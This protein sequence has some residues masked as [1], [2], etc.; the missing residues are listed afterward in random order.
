M[1]LGH[2][3]TVMESGINNP[4][5]AGYEDIV[6]HT[7]AGHTHVAD[8]TD[9]AVRFTQVGAVSQV[10]FRSFTLS[11]DSSQ[12]GTIH[13][14]SVR[15]YGKSSHLAL[16]SLKP[17]PQGGTLDNGFFVGNLI[18]SSGEVA[19]LELTMKA[20]FVRWRGPRNTVP[21]VESW[22]CCG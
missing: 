21:S 5:L 17:H 11:H 3:P 4:M 14:N 7:F 20:N 19:S 8:D 9:T 12:F 15:W 1:V 10:G 22:K 16:A 18:G 2:Y 13:S 6:F